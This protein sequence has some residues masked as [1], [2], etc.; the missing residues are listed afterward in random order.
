MP[1][2]SPLG[3]QVLNISTLAPYGLALLW[4]QWSTCAVC[5]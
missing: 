3:F 5:G 4:A 1:Q 2:K